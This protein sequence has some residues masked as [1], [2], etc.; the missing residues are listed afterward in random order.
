GRL[1][2]RGRGG[3]HGALAAVVVTTAVPA[4]QPGARADAEDGDADAD[5]GDGRY[6][7]AGAASAPSATAAAGRPGR[8]CGGCRGC[9]GAGSAVLDAGELLG[10][11]GRAAAVTA[12]EAVELGGGLPVARAGRRGAV[13]LP[14]RL[15]GDGGN[16]L[17]G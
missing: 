2:A 4:A 12:E 8:V 7:A 1:L 10:G 13:G 5:R 3:R 9:G 11:S 14:G 6:A 15:V 16:V 17:G